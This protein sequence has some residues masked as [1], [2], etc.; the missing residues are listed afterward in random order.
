MKRLVVFALIM[1][2]RAFCA[3]AVPLHCWIVG[4]N[5]GDAAFAPQS[6][7][8]LVDSTNIIFTQAALS[9]EVAS[10]N[11]TNDSR[12]V[13]VSVTNDTQYV[14]LCNVTNNTGGLELYFVREVVDGA[15]AFWTRLGVVVGRRA[16][17]T[18]LAHEIGHACGLDD[19]YEAH[20]GT[21]LVVTGLPSK[22]RIPDDWGW[23]PE[24][25]TQTTVVRRLLMYGYNT[26][27]KA[28]ISRGDVFGLGYT[29]IWSSTEEKWNKSYFL[30]LI[31]VGFDHH[32][33][34][35]PVSE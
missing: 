31:P 4:D 15:D 6:I 5:D 20:V 10:I 28:D 26:T 27:D 1:C 29:N 18:T 33:V 7:S 35:H 9:F 34:R 30:G 8:N 2:L 11:Y 23:Y 21:S 32:G 3:A 14:A 25:V 19:I 16:N 13:E 12:Y 17:S 24:R 22:E